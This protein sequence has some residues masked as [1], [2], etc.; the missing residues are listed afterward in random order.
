MTEEIN[1][2]P[3]A[4]T[5]RKSGRTVQLVWLIPLIAALLGGW[6]ALKSVMDRGPVITIS[7]KTA[8]GLEAGKTKL[9]FKDV[10]IGQVSTVELAPDLQ[11]VIATADLVKGF[12]ARLV[13]DAKFWVVRPRVSGGSVSGIGTVLSGSYISVG[14]GKSV[15][16]RRDFIG[17]EVPPILSTDAPG[18]EYVLKSHNLGSLDYG[19]PV[20]FRRL[21]VGQVTGYELDKD[22]KGV[23]LRAF[24]NAPYDQYVNPNSRFWHSSGV[25]V[26]LDASGIKVDTQSLV[27]IVIGGL[28][29]ETPAGSEVLP[30]AGPDLPFELF[31]SREEALKNPDT[32][33]MKAIMVFNE[34]V[35]GLTVGA[36]VDFR[37]ID[38]GTVTAIKVEINEANQRVNVAVEVDL[39]PER[40]RAGETRQR[41]ALSDKQRLAVLNGMISRGL[42]AQLRSGNLVTGQLYVALDFVRDPPEAKLRS[43]GSMVEIPTMPGSLEDLKASITSVARKLE[44]IDYEGIST[45]L[46]NTLNSTTRMVKGLETTVADIAPEAKAVIAEAQRAMAAAERAIAPDSPILQDTRAMTMEVSRAAQAI[47]L[48]ADYL[49]RHPEALVSGKKADEPTNP[50]KQNDERKGESR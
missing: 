30:P 39:Y 10:E 14:I 37:G 22:G 29:F 15:Q 28:A 26:T 40:L 23:T 21:Q 27:S 17:L 49:E 3:E 18:R 31:N 5:G 44:K 13:D 48:L 34:S 6:L 35:R 38:I 47:R 41:T 45:D 7:F 9:K 24:V 8:E 25:D 20:F 42:R 4:V 50:A 36:P 11:S 16:A 43:I 12:E 33:I 1:D 46:R 19:S 2:I 32:L